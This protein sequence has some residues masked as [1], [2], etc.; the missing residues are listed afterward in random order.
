MTKRKAA[1]MV[2][3]NPQC[4]KMK[5]TTPDEPALGYYLGKGTWHLA[6]GGGPLPGLYACSEKCILPAIQAAV[7]GELTN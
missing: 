7:R 6:G 1:V 5:L 4:G 3:D 2:C